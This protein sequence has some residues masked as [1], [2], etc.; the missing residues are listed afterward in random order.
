M[1]VNVLLCGYP[2]LRS[3]FPPEENVAYGFLETENG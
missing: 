1:A 2:K 3:N